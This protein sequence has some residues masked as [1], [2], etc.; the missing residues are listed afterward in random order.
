MT[1]HTRIARMLIAALALAAMSAPALAQFGTLPRSITETPSVSASQ[2]AEIESFV[3]GRL[4][5]ATENDGLEAAEARRDLAT[6]L[7]TPGVSVA[8]RRAY[9]NAL[10]PVFGGLDARA[11]AGS[12]IAA[13]R[14]AGELGT[15]D[16]VARIR[17]ALSHDDLGIRVFAAGR[18]GRVFRVTTRSG[19]A[20]E[21][22]ELDA[23]I[24]ELGA[25]AADDA[26]PEFRGAC[27]RA[28]GAGAML[29]AS[30][31]GVQRGASIER[32][33]TAGSTM[34][35]SLGGSIEPDP[36]VRAIVQAAGDGTS[37]LSAVGVRTAPE[38][39]RAAAAL[40]ADMIA[41]GLSGVVNETIGS[42]G[43]RGL[44]VTVVRSGESLLYFA[45]REHAQ[46]TGANPG[47]VEQ[48]DLAAMLEAGE[49]RDFRNAAALL[50]G[51]GSPIVTEMDFKDDRFVN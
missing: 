34:V 18:A 46:N 5:D 28:L 24:D 16:A 29:P 2:R 14:L 21:P 27:M 12:A 6:P 38:A 49:D 9:D 51:P 30:A 41:L 43:E 50:L 11:D 1:T 4:E 44:V 8:F 35:G 3:S 31:F 42:P 10:T 47:S 40:G 17:S 15:P 39:V 36:L 13:L 7:L 48:T 33:S 22:A 32:M 19:A 26:H 37:S 25:G 45:L 20:L 23:L